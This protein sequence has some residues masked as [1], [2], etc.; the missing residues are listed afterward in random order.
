MEAGPREA[1]VTTNDRLRILVHSSVTTQ[2]ML[3]RRPRK[4]RVGDVLAAT[5]AQVAKFSDLQAVALSCGG[6]L[7]EDDARLE[8][9]VGESKSTLELSVVFSK[10][11]GRRPERDECLPALPGPRRS[12]PA[13]RRRVVVPVVFP[14]IGGVY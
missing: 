6:Y 4:A 12:G 11:A 10:D 7:L 3:F 9:V 5:A 13:T 8:D 1:T 2:P 14:K